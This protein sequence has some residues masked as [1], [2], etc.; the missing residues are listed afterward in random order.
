MSRSEWAW[1]ESRARVS[2]ASERCWRAGRVRG[3]SAPR[4][5]VCAR[6]GLIH[7][8]RSQ[9]DRGK[10][11]GVGCRA[12]L[13]APAGSASGSHARPL[14]DRQATISTMFLAPVACCWRWGAVTRAARRGRCGCCSVAWCGRGYAPG[15]IDGRYGPRTA[16]AVSRFQ[17]AHGLVVDGIAG[18]FTLAALSERVGG[19]V[20][21]R[22][23]RGTWLRSCARVAASPAAG[24]VRARAD[25]WSLRSADRAGGQSFPGR[26]RL[27]GR[28]DR[29]PA[30]T[31]VIWGSGAAT[32]PPAA[33]VR[34]ARISGR[35]SP[36][37]G[38]G[39]RRRPTIGSPRRAPAPRKVVPSAF[40]NG[41]TIDRS[42]RAVG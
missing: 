16:Q 19:V 24:G 17:A 1:M 34:W 2:V 5:W 21:R 42:A 10:C 40:I 23:L 6:R 26:P 20:S 8:T 30:D 22:G 9:V 38:G 27:A 18:P 33:R 15:P 14:A 4:T 28:R 25:R 13:G 11:A 29:R 35:S 39:S 31:R 36:A 41:L 12:G 32:G 37:R 3:P 7:E